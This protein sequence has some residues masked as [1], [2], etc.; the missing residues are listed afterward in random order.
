MKS[1]RSWLFLAGF[2]LAIAGGNGCVPMSMGIFTPVPV[3]PWM[4]DQ[5]EN[6]MQNPSDHKTTVL[7]P[8]PAGYRPLCEDPPDRST[9]LRALPPV[10]RGVPYMYE[11]FRDDLDFSIVRL[12]DQVDPPRFYPL[13]GPAQL[14]HCHY[15]CTVFYTETVSSDWP[16]PFQVKR[17]RSEVVYIDRDHLHAVACTPEQTQSMTRDFMQDQP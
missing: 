1:L 12:V 3:Q 8:I 2:S 4:S 11:Q 10:T 14:H 17:R 13:V 9:I 15:K 16:I 7:G 5:V 6:R